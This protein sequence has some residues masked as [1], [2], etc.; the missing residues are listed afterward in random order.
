M[1]SNNRIRGI[2]IEFGGDTTKLDKALSGVNKELNSIDKDLKDVNKLLKLDPKN[3][4]LLAQKQKLLAKAVDDSSQKLKT[5]RD[6]EKQL[7]NSGVDENSEQFMKLRREIIETEQKMNSYAATA[8]EASEKTSVNWKKVGATVVTV[9][10][11]VVTAAVGAAKAVFDMTKKSAEYADEVDKASIRMGISAERFQELRYAAE[12]SGV[13]LSTLESAAKK[14]EGTGVTLDQ[15]FDQIMSI[16][17]AE[18]RAAKASEL[19]G[20]KIAYTLSPLIEQSGDDFKALTKRANELGLV[21]STKDVKAGVKLGDTLDDVKQSVSALG[22]QL[23]AKLMPLVQKVLDRLL[24][25]LPKLFDFI[26]RIAPLLGDLFDTVVPPLMEIAEQLMPPIMQLIEAL[27]P[28]ITSIAGFV[29]PLI[30]PL[31][32]IVGLVA[33]ILAGFQPI[34]DV[35]FDKDGD[36]SK[37]AEATKG[38]FSGMID[39]IKETLNGLT[40]FLDGVL[41]GDEVKIATGL[42]NIAIGFVNAITRIINGL[43]AA[44]ANFKMNNSLLG[45]LYGDYIKPLDA[46]KLI[47]KIPTVSERQ[48]AGFIGVDYMADKNKKPKSTGGGHQVMY[49][50]GGV[51]SDWGIVGERGPELVAVN[52]GKAT[53]TPLT[54]NNSYNSTL[55]GVTINV[56]QQP[57]QSGASLAH[58]IS[59]VLAEQYARTRAVYQ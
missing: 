30:A 12:Q 40:T 50:E 44:I 57:G 3:T 51:I 25:H 17:T 16:E 53:V 23:G 41:K 37:G 24:Q 15:A 36:L 26:D 27:L 33:D 43:I 42:V 1:A 52:G 32:D 54:N 22:N 56:S 59:E 13:E 8:K 10:A 7:K 2:T 58:Q 48:V 20:S 11:S 55:G 19:F 18:G 39:S 38:I 45:A 21:M 34:I 29:I 46:S 14:L 28:I 35:L 31:T 9:G 4:E 6:A 49:A 5:L 47:P